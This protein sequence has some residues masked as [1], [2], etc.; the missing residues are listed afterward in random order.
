MSRT[1]TYTTAVTFTPVSS[2]AGNNYAFTTTTTAASAI[3]QAY[4]DSNSTTAARLQVPSTYANYIYDA[5]FYFDS[6]SISEI[7]NS[8]YSL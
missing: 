5:Y 7:P 2:G 1:T 4:S 8:L 6:T 3:T